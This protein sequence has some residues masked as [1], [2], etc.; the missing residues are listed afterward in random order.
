[1]VV[2]RKLWRK[3]RTRR[4]D[5]RSEDASLDGW[6]DTVG[7]KGLAARERR[8]G[9]ERERERAAAATATTAEEEEEEEEEAERARESEKAMEGTGAR[10]YSERICFPG[11]PRAKN[12]TAVTS[13]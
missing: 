2:S 11:F 7:E 10:A 5:G 4:K 6:R 1:M 12:M 9:D 13:V 3:G 8:E